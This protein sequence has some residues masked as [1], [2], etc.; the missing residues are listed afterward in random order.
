M[1]I[2]LKKLR[3]YL[4]G[5]A[6]EMLRIRLVFNVT[7]CVIKDFVTQVVINIK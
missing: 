3:C 4:K 6:N 7:D 1:P 2:D 5:T